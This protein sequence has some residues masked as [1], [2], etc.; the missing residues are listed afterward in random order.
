VTAADFDRAEVDFNRVARSAAEAVAGRVGLTC[1]T[2]AGGRRAVRSLAE[3]AHRF[4]LSEPDFQV[5]W[6]LRSI[7]GDGLDQTTL[8]RQLAYSPAQVSGTVERMRS[9]GWIIQRQLPGDRRRHLWRLSESGRR[10]LTEMLSAA[11][12]LQLDFISDRQ[13]PLPECNEHEAAA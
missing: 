10:L 13:P 6:S 1:R 9:A 4:Q 3:W 12:S 8:A 2:A 11:S 7:A 5:L